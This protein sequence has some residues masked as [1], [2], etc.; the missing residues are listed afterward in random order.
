[1]KK[2][3]VLAMAAILSAGCSQDMYDFMD[4]NINAPVVAEPKVE[5]F[6]AE[7]EIEVYWDK[8]DAADEYILYRDTNPIMGTFD[9]ICYRGQDLHFKDT[10]LES[11]GG[12]LY[13]Y[14]LAKRR[15]ERVFDK[16]DFVL[17]VAHTKRRD[18][19]EPNNTPETAAEFNVNA[20]DAN[21]YYYRCDDNHKLEDVDWYWVMVE[22]HR[23][24]IIRV[25]FPKGGEL[26]PY[27]IYFEEFEGHNSVFITGEEDNIYIRNY[28]NEA[29]IKSFCIRVNIIYFNDVGGKMGNYQIRF[30]HSEPVPTE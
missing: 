5:C 12:K 1:M 26:E 15:A 11:D 7:C 4:R 9:E 23:Q 8:D 14:K 25:W 13:Y 17:G 28:E 30:L 3:I 29:C 6:K 2:I 22:P 19:Y 21:I 10:E 18:A 20:I 16:S 24:I 27:D